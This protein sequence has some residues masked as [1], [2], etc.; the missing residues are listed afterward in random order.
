MPKMRTFLPAMWP[1]F[2]IRVRPASRKA[3]PACMNIT[4][5]AVMTTQI[6]LAA[7][8]R[9][10]FLGTGLH[11][12]EL[13]SRA[14]VHHAVDA[15]APHDPVA[16]F[17]AAPGGVADHRGDVVG[18]LVLDEED[19]QRLR[20]EARL[21]HTTA[22]LVRDAALPAVPHRLDHGHAYMSGRLLDCIDH[23]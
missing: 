20:Q 16:R 17:V 10:E 6:V 22:V 19:Q 3:K 23:G 8:R 9:S 11:L 2:F 12:L 14:V 13:A 4:S 5:T 15:R 18:D 21:E 1:A 7:M